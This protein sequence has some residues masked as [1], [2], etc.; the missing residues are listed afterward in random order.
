MLAASPASRTG[1]AVEGGK[2]PPAVN[3][4]EQAAVSMA[5]GSSATSISMRK[6]GITLFHT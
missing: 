5:M 2:V 3:A 6:K 4:S 1:L